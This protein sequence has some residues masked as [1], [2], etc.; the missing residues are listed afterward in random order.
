VVADKDVLEQ[1][2]FFLAA[3]CFPVLT[4]PNFLFFLDLTTQV[5][6]DKFANSLVEMFFLPFG[7][8]SSELIPLV[9]IEKDVF[10]IESV[11]GLVLVRKHLFGF[12]KLIIK[13]LVV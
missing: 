7:D 11:V 8:D 1:L 5:P 6:F 4:K 13:G 3:D 9:F 10:K 2:S 12:L